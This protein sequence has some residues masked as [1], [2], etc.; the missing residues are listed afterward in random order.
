[1]VDEYVPTVLLPFSVPVQNPTNVRASVSRIPKPLGSDI[2]CINYCQRTTSHFVE[3]NPLILSHNLRENG[4][5]IQSLDG[6][7]L[8][9]L[10]VNGEPPLFPLLVW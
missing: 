7:T 9:Y 4:S 3:T 6:V 1:M 8:R 2:S 5:K 10:M